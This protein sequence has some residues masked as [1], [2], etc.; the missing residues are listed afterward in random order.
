MVSNG[1]CLT[2]K[3]IILVCRIVQTSTIL[4]ALRRKGGG[5]NDPK[6]PQTKKS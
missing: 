5:L 1:R 3:D 4:Y 6:L 2:G